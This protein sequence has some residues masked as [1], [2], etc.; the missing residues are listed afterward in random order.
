MRMCILG[1]GGYLGQLLAQ[2]LQN[3]GGHFVV[4][5]DLNFFASFPHIKLNEELTQRIEG[6]IERSD[7][8]IEALTGCD[9]CFHLA[10]YGM[11]GGPSLNKEKCFAINYWGT[12][13]VIEICKN[14]GVSRLVFTSSV[15]VIF[16]GHTELYM[17]DENTPYLQSSQYGNYYAES[18]S[19]AEQLILAENCPPKFST[20]ALRLR[21]IY[22]P[23]EDF[24]CK[25]VLVTF[26]KSDVPLTQFSSAENTVNALLLSEQSLRYPNSPAAGNKY[27]IVDG[28]LNYSSNCIR[29]PYS[30]I[31]AFAFLCELLYRWF[32]I[33]PHLTRFECAIV[34]VTNTFSCQRAMRDFG[35]NPIRSHDLHSTIDFCL[36]Q[37]EVQLKL[38]SR[39]QINENDNKKYPIDLTVP[40]S[41][42]FS[43]I[44]WIWVAW[45]V[46]SICSTKGLIILSK[47][48]FLFLLLLIA[49]GHLFNNNIYDNLNSTNSAGSVAHQTSTFVAAHRWW[50]F[51]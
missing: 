11:S 35:Y 43:P 29:A 15:V 4:L 22:G 24:L 30:V 51:F 16:D 31:Y 36:K 6:S 20:C 40:F 25:N 46:D 21:G 1:G 14:L 34:G 50:T 12:K 38:K 5:F 18:K 8:L 23:G 19:A 32:G 3:E 39:Q 27:H 33:E 13:N 10:G 41:S 47:C 9:A 48:A 49:G 37:K 17:A 42:I 28:A 2:A 44:N 45:I 26:W 7:Q